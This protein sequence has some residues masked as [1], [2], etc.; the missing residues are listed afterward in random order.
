MKEKEFDREMRHESILKSGELVMAEFY[1]SW[2]PHCQR[3]MP[4]VEEFKR[5]A[6]GRVQVVQIDIEEEADLA[7]F[8]TIETIPTFILLRRGETLWRQ[9]GELTVE[10]LE[11]AVKEEA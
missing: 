11:R 9:S 2:C 1:A 7:N 5:L 4:V 6:E 10:R 8:Y 3:M